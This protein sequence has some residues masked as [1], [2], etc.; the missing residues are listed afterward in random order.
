MLIPGSAI[1]FVGNNSA[2]DT[3]VK[4]S[5]SNYHG[6]VVSQLVADLFQGRSTLSLATEASYQTTLDFDQSTLSRTYYAATVQS[7][8][9]LGHKPELLLGLG[10]RAERADFE[11]TN[12]NETRTP[13]YSN[14]N[15][16]L[17]L[18]G[19][20]N[21]N[22]SLRFIAG[23]AYR[24]PSIWE[25]TDLV[26]GDP[27]RLNLR[28]GN[29]SLQP[30]E[31]RS[32]EIGYLGHPRRWL[33][34]DLTGYAQQLR[35]LVGIPQ[36]K[37][38]FVYENLDT[39]SSAGAELA[40]KIRPTTAAGAHLA[41]S[42]THPLNDPAKQACAFPTHLAQIGGDGRLGEFRFSAD[43]SYASTV[44]VNRVFLTTPG[45]PVYSSNT[46]A[47]QFLLGARVA[48]KLL[49]GNAELFVHGNNLLAPL[50]SRA[51]LV[52]YPSGAADPIGLIVL[53]GIALNDSNLGGGL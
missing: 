11:V 26:I 44:C 43:F 18:I 41:Y 50:R 8:T 51:D 19:R 21:E 52:Q 10:L 3:L 31:L 6:H 39:L 13:R 28:R 40:V 48:R 45:G 32:A 24:T 5:P 9:R 46:S 4:L 2:A 22:H 36:Q 15:P 23:S 27:V 53:V 49:H 20:F 38:P 47:S 33:R 42:W 14:V 7:E 34:L 1:S 17:S 37:V 29:M 25:L 35:N 12:A 16:R 30:E